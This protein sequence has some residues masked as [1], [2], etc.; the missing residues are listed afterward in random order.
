MSTTGHE[1]E[2]INVQGL[3]ASL[4]KL[5]T[6]HIDA[7]AAARANAVSAEATRAQ[8]AEENLRQLYNNLQQSQPIPVT[9]LPATGEAGKI[10]RLAGTTSYADYMYAEDDL[11]TPIKMAEYN[12]AIDNEPIPGSD[13]LVKSSG[14]F[15][16]INDAIGSNRVSK[17]GSGTAYYL[18]D[19]IELDSTFNFDATYILNVVNNLSASI[20]VTLA[21]SYKREQN[22]DTQ[23][24]SIQFVLYTEKQQKFI[25]SELELSSAAIEHGWTIEDTKYLRFTVARTNQAVSIDYW[26][27]KC[28][29]DIV[30]LQNEIVKKLDKD[31]L[32][33]V[34]DTTVEFYYEPKI[35]NITADSV[36]LTL[37]L[38]GGLTLGWLNTITGESFDIRYQ[39]GSTHVDLTVGNGNCLVLEKTESYYLAKL[40]NYDNEFYVNSSKYVLVLHAWNRQYYGVMG[41]IVERFRIRQSGNIEEN[42]YNDYLNDKVKSFTKN[43]LEGNTINDSF[44][45]LTDSHVTTNYG[46]SGKIVKSLFEKSFIYKCIFGGDVCSVQNTQSTADEVALFNKFIEG[47]IKSNGKLYNVKGN[48]DF[49]NR[50]DSLPVSAPY[51]QYINDGADIVKNESSENGCYYYFDNKIAKI[52]YIVYDSHE[53]VTGYQ[54]VSN[55]QIKWLVE[56]AFMTTPNGYNVILIGHIPFI[57]LLDSL[58]ENTEG[59]QAHKLDAL[60]TLCDAAKNHLKNIT[61]A[62]ETYDFTNFKGELIMC[63]SGHEHMDIQTYINGLLFVTTANDSKYDDQRYSP[64][65]LGTE[66][67]EANSIKEQLMDVVTVKGNEKILFQRIG[68]GYDRDFNLNPITLSVGGTRQLSTSLAVVSWVS[69]DCARSENN[70]FNPSNNTWSYSS[71]ICSVSSSGLVTGLASGEAFV[72]ADDANH[73]KEFFYIKVE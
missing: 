34:R 11:T 62:G 49:Y 53:G 58:N 70:R 18:N 35:K 26:I 30:E 69:N 17:G 12:N 27:S 44:V 45:F 51:N 8:A 7:E 55:A 39:N 63:L 2:A 54:N 4:Q 65:Y 1:S 42:Y 47:P 23:I 36:D 52:R 29:P 71:N 67:K 72:F 50:M 66:L 20:T 61:L 24:A 22:I 59:T 6:N 25:P 33:K 28:N 16:M 43:Y 13:N 40:V 56:E 5:K 46:Q 41:P 73:N 19:Y 9:A 68:I 60:I 64:F 31:P 3:K 48:H 10:Y 14:I 21:F 32:Y 57:P 38:A 15:N 37:Q